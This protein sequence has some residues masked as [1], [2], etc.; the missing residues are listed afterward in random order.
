MNAREIPSEFSFESNYID[1]HGSKMHYIDES[2][3]DPILFLHGNP[4]SVYLWRNII[5]H[6]TPFGR[7]V[8]PDLIGMGKSDK[9]DIEYRFAD[10]YRYLDAFIEAL[11][12]DNITLVV[13]DWGSALGLHYAHQNPERIKG[14]ALMEAM[15]KPLTWSGF[16][17]KFRLIFKMMRAPVIGPLMV[18]VGNVFVTQVVPQAIERKLRPEEVAAYQE[19]FPTIASRKPVLVFPRE[20]PIDGKP[21]DVHDVISGYSTWLT[22]ADELPKLLFH[23][24][25]G[26]TIDA[27][28]VAWATA[29]FDNLSLVDV[30]QGTHYIQEDHPQLIGEELAKWIRGLREVR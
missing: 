2:A 28:T 9:P 18:Q 6:V 17:P 8:A 22:A 27:E 25:P 29:N 30:G 12:L 24:D 4:S 13:H 1:I 15:I 7:A 20:I 10:H 14:V 11:E 19:P 21:S 16:E 3:G 23:A 26:G 5:G